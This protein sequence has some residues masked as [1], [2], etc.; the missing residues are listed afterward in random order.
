MTLRTGRSWRRGGSPSGILFAILG[1]FWTTR[2]IETLLRPQGTAEALLIGVDWLPG[3]AVIPIARCA[4]IVQALCGVT[5]FSGRL[6]RW[7]AATGLGL[8]SVMLAFGIVNYD[9]IAGHPCGCLGMFGVYKFGA[10]SIV[11]LVVSQVGFLM[12][13]AIGFFRGPHARHRPSRVPGGDSRP[14]PR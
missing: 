2:G 8:C 14:L 4:G 12:G 13:A 9:R 7:G 5:Q 10:G 6:R 11:V 1:L 3:V